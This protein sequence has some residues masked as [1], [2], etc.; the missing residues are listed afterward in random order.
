MEHICPTQ[1]PALVTA[2]GTL[3]ALLTPSTFLKGCANSTNVSATK[4][5]EKISVDI[6]TWIMSHVPYQNGTATVVGNTHSCQG[7]MAL[8]HHDMRT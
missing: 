8:K 2:I 7:G 5:A 3:L 4:F 6:L 1:K